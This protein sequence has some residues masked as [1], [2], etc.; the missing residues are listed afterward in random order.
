LTKTEDFK[1]RAAIPNLRPLKLPSGTETEAAVTLTSAL[2]AYLL[3]IERSQ[4]N[5][6]V[7]RTSW[8]G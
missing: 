2:L 1:T 6:L 3:W 7:H 4:A 8:C 5:S